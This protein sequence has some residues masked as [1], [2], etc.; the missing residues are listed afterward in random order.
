MS[1]YVGG[2]VKPIALYDS[3]TK[4]QADG[5]F[6]DKTSATP[7]DFTAMPSVGGDPVVESG[8]NAD[9]E[10]TRWADGTQ[11][12]RRFNV[13]ISI[14]GPTVN[15]AFTFP[16]AFFNAEIC[17]TYAANNSAGSAILVHYANRQ[18]TNTG[19]AEV[20]FAELNL[21]TFT[22]SSTFGYSVFG[23]WK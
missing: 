7:Q 21:R 6:P 18:L 4:G 10:W 1:G 15:T 5:L 12:C 19:V 3:Y 23:R 14:S 11:H 20:T 16:L 17:P 8:S 13:P 9:G 22:G 2:G